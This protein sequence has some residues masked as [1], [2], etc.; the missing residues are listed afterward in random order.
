MIIQEQTKKRDS[1]FGRSVSFLWLLAISLVSSC[2]PRNY[3]TSIKNIKIALDKRDNEQI[4]KY[5]E[6]KKTRSSLL[7]DYESGR[8]NILGEVVQ[9]NN[10]ILLDKLI[11]LGFNNPKHNTPYLDTALLNEYH[12]IAKIL[13]GDGC[14]TQLIYPNKRTVD[15]LFF[16]ETR[17]TYPSINSDSI[18]VCHYKDGILIESGVLFKFLK[19]G[20]WYVWYEDGSTYHSKNVFQKG[21]LNGMCV[22]YYD[23]GGIKTTV[24]YEK[25]IISGEM[26][27][28]S[29]KGYLIERSFY[30]EGEPHGT[31]VFFNSDGNM[32]RILQYSQGK[33]IDEQIF[34]DKEK[35]IPPR[36]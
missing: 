6:D 8:Y 5:L 19:E 11:S 3:E 12:L 9:T 4:L 34:S 27:S 1:L 24:N 2:A 31:F 32:E 30:L 7:K 13:Y 36:E 35:G 21:K 23:N 15:S 14:R 29:R 28:F 26:L 16:F 20:I 33:V 10:P 22:L 18:K 17:I 25:D